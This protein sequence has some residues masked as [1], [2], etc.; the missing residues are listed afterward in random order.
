MSI[1]QIDNQ[2]RLLNTGDVKR[3]C[4][5]PSP[6]TWARYRAIVG[7]THRTLT[8]REAFLLFVCAQCCR[9]RPNIDAVTVWAAAVELL[10]KRPDSGVMLSRLCGADGVLGRDL[11]QA[12]EAAI[13]VSVSERALYEWG[14]LPKMPRFSRDARYNGQQIRRFVNLAQRRLLRQKSAA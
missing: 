6:K 1:F 5:N 3:A 9:Q 13:G 12:I 10:D 2:E 14:R 8:K 4:G 11:P 7:V